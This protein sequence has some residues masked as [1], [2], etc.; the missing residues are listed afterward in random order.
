MLSWNL[1]QTLNRAL[2]HASERRHEYATLEHL[3]LSLTDDQDS[4]AVMKACGI[5][6]ELLVL[7]V[8]EFLDQELD[9]L[10][11]QS[12]STKNMVKQP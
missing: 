8:T 11:N 4:V 12:H 7:A 3:L 5:E 1:E 9:P 2:S 6:L 10:G